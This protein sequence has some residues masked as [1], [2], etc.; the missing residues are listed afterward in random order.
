MI[1]YKYGKDVFEPQK[2]AYTNQ[3]TTTKLSASE[4]K[5]L[6]FLID[7]S[8][9][10]ISREKLLEIGWPDKVVVPNSLNVA[11]ANLRKA[12]KSKNEIII[13]IKGAGFTIAN[14]TF[15]QQ[16]FQPE[17]IIDTKQHHAEQQ[18]SIDNNTDTDNNTISSE[19]NHITAT[20]KNKSLP[21]MTKIGYAVCLTVM[22]AWI[23]L[24][25][26]SWQSPPCVTVNN[27]KI[28]GN[29]GL[30]NLQKLPQNLSGKNTIYIDTTGK[31]YEKI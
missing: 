19:V 11:I 30:L 31:T 7:N 18:Q 23:M 14:N 25:A 20:Q 10:I 24:W 26:S 3:E 21:T 12:F 5:I 27:Q 6:Q 8:G 16:Q 15:I 13:T 29:I 2:S 28:C 4:T 17:A 9:E 22:F 1:I